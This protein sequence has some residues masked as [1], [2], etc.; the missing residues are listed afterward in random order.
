MRIA[1]SHS[2]ARSPCDSIATPGPRA[3]REDPPVWGR[4]RY[5]GV[6]TLALVAALL[7]CGPDDGGATPPPPTAPP[8]EPSLYSEGPEEQLIR[9][10]FRDRRNGFFLDVG[11]ADPIEYSTT[12]F[13]EKH[14]GWSGIA[15]DALPQYA[16]PWAEKRPASRFFQYL[17]SDHSDTV[18]PFYE[19]DYEGFRGLSSIEKHRRVGGMRVSSHAIEVPTITLTRLLD[20]HDIESIDLL[21][22][23]IEEAEPRALAGFEIERFAPELVVIEASPSIQPELEAYFGAHHY[24]RIARYLT[25]DPVNWYYRKAD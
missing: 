1:L 16:A 11:A 10:F 21:S 6:A 8:A 22:M 17:V 12:Y 24:E 7:G 15:V 2:V 3:F 20:D 19:T 14:L 23:D 5:R 25:I 18:E 4:R 13:L 9:E